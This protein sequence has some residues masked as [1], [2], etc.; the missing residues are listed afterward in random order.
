MH[1]GLHPMVVHQPSI[2]PARKATRQEPGPT[3][4][5]AFALG[6]IAANGQNYDSM[7]TLPVRL[8]PFGHSEMAAFRANPADDPQ[9]RAYRDEL[10]AL[11]GAERVAHVLSDNRLSTMFYPSASVQATSLQ[12]RVIIPEAVDRTTI[13]IWSFRLAG[14]PDSL[15]R[16]T[17]ALANAAHSPSSLIKH[18]DFA[19][20]ARVQAGLAGESLEW[21]DDRRGLNDPSTPLSEAYIRNQFHAWRDYMAA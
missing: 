21:I 2:D 19:I 20:Y 3:G 7:A 15:H 5:T 17:I 6:V 12:M 4:N 9:F 16:R 13:E 10:V 18:D 11:H 8:Y 14:A 1:D